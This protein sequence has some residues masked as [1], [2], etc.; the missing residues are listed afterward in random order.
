MTELARYS[1]AEFVGLNNNAYQIK[2][3]N[4]KIQNQDVKSRCRFVHGDFMNIPEEDCSF[5]GAY[6]IESMPHAPD[7]TAAFREIMRILRP[8][9]YFSGYDWCLTELFDPDNPDH[10]R[11]ARD[12][13]IG[14]ALPQISTTSQVYDALGEA[15]FE[16]IEARDLALD[17]EDKYPWYAPLEGRDYS[18]RGLPRTPA[19]RAITNLVLRMGEKLRVVPKGARAVSTF[20]NNGADAFVESGKSGVF[21]V[22]YFFLARKP[23]LSD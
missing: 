20:L 5:D 21:S 15:G 8:G 2:R 13:A 14:N 10:E 3:A 7:K 16:V 6:A 1:G 18:L 17:S 22:M 4:Q 12:I 19:G 23:E 9:G 11:M